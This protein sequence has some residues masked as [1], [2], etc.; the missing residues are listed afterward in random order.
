MA[1]ACKAWARVTG[2]SLALARIRVPRLSPIGNRRN[3][4]AATENAAN[5]FP[6]SARA[7][8]PP[9]WSGQII[10]IDQSL[11]NSS[12]TTTSLVDSFPCCAAL[13]G[14]RGS[15]L[16]RTWLRA[17]ENHSYGFQRLPSRAISSRSL[18]TISLT[19]WSKLVWCRQPSFDQLVNEMVDKDLELMARDGNRWKPYE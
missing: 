4:P 16:A 3:R 1:R 13:C 2:R 17:L 11:P 5:F 12:R 14:Y 10:A 7:P 19:S 9:T 6:P 18:S 15:A 8:G